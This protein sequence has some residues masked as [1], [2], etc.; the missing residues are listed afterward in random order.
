MI[1]W[2]QKFIHFCFFLINSIIKNLS[3]CFAMKSVKVFFFIIFISLFIDSSLLLPQEKFYTYY[4]KGLEY[5]KK[6]DCLRAIEEFKSAAS[7]EFEDTKKKRTYGTRFIKYFPHREMGIAYYNLGEYDNARRELELSIAYRK[8]KSSIEYIQKL[9][10]I[11]E[12]PAKEE[13]VAFEEIRK[14]EEEEKRLT[15][16]QEQIAKARKED[17][18]RLKAEEE[19]LKRERDRAT[20]AKKEEREKLIAEEERLQKKRER[21][22][23]EYEETAKIE[24]ELEKKR[25]EFEKQRERLEKQ[26]KKLKLGEKTLSME[27]LKY[28]P[29]KV[30]RVG[31]RLSIAVMPFES[32]GELEDLGELVT[33]K[34][35]TK[36]VNLR[37][38]RVIERV[39]MDEI[40]KEQALGISGVVDEAMAI[41]V[42]KI[43]GADAIVLGS[44]N[45]IQ[46]FVTIKSRL[47][48]I[49]TSETI[50]AKEVQSENTDI[51]SI[52]QIV[53]NLAIK[54]YNDIPL[55][56]GYIVNV[57]P[58][59]IYLDI[60]SKVGVRKG[61]KCVAFREG[62]KIV[63][64]VTG[65]FLGK[66]VTKLGELVVVQVQDKLSIAKFVVEKGKVEVGDKVVVK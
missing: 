24:K 22:V 66:K 65:E 15:K 5:M 8:S 28:D 31:S 49:E 38:F 50:V 13:K 37:R 21:I 27:E 19:K 4:S 29:S 26:I 12:L 64:P 35:I 63:H 9:K 18:E 56:G 48:D 33:E 52:E 23:R 17:E 58:E 16:E 55:V 45:L 11:E 43:A 61:T 62:N 51:R 42:G 1:K 36:L 32:K 25:R 30:I 20:L 53:E 41:E 59:L 3:L 60:G 10:G 40:M 14:I 54:I 6:G 57:E 44:C 7:M 39:A 2:K 47:I 46:G 34:L